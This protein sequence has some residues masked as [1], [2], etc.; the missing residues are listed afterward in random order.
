MKY[1]LRQYRD[2]YLSALEGGTEKEK[3]TLTKNFLILLSKDKALSR[4]DH[5]A[6]EIRRA[7]LKKLGRHEAYIESASK[8]PPKE[9]RELETML[10]K[11]AIIHEEVRPE[12]LAGMTMLV[13]NELFIDASGKRILENILPKTKR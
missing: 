10:G 2:A 13:D 9:K 12:L 11:H 1:R 3:E 7:H 6:K 8:L 5:L 4:V